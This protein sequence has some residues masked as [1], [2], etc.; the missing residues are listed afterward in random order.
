MKLLRRILVRLAVVGIGVGAALGLALVV[1]IGVRI[2]LPHLDPMVAFCASPGFR[3]DLEFPNQ[4][5]AT[6]FDAE[7]DWR[8]APNLKNLPWCG[9]AVTTNSDGIRMDKPLLPKATGTVRI[10]CL[11]DSVTF[12]YGIPFYWEGKW[13]A[14][15][16]AY[17]A[18]M[19]A[20]LHEKAGGKNVEV[21]SLACPG[22]TSEQGR[23]WFSQLADQLDADIVTACF[24]RNDVMSF[25]VPDRR[26]RTGAFSERVVRSLAPYSQTITHLVANSRA[27]KGPPSNP[28]GL[29]YSRLSLEESVE[30]FWQIAQLVRSRGAEFVV[31]A[32]I[33][34]DLDEEPQEGA[35]MAAL[36]GALRKL[37][38]KGNLRWLEIQELT[39]A[40]HPRN[41]NLFMERIHPNVEGHQLLGQRAADFLVEIVKQR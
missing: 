6:M 20:A 7:R 27:K 30:N 18:V 36:R 37:C 41:G 2:C 17:P 3:L 40:G 8:L 12:G 1:E 35:R 13:N 23:L 29:E 9:A 26:I 25:G 11:G 28:P 32:P 39:E 4:L 22:Y 31:I 15:E 21:I 10:V 5:K 16:K 38:E 14:A 33:Y 34:R 19:E 24:G